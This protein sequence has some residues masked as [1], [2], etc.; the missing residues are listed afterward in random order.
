LPSGSEY[1]KRELDMAIMLIDQLQEHFEAAKYHNEYA[2]AIQKIIE[3]K[4]RGETIRVSKD[5]ELTPTTDM[6]QLMEMLRKSLEKE[7]RAGKPATPKERSSQ[8]KRT[9]KRSERISV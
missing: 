5:K 7:K 3:R 4:A 9:T 6:R 8:S 1:S 2:Q